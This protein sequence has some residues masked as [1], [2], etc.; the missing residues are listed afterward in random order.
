MKL[1]A[2]L[3][4]I[5]ASLLMAGSAQAA[6]LFSDSLQ[7]TLASSNW[8]SN[9]T[10][11]IVTAPD[12]FKALNFAGL[13]SGGDLFSTII[14]GTNHPGT[15]TIQ[16]DYYSATRGGAGGFIGLYPTPTT[17]TN[18][19]LGASDDWL[20]SDTPAAYYTP[21]TFNGDF[22][23][24]TV[25]FSFDI[26]SSTP[27][28]LKLEDFVGSGGSAGDAYF[29]NLTVSDA[30]VTAVPEPIT[31]SIFGAGLAGAAALRRRKKA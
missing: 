25:S 15:Y 8:A 26:V 6:V 19:F 29:R 23:F 2:T 17:V 21:F 11:Q 4:A 22:A 9:N 1:S 27:F 14:A 7:T 10:G 16:F 18:P 31:L 3:V 28:G 5:G 24:T 13:G 20:A 12:G 30:A